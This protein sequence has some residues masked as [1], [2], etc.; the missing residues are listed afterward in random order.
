MRS[1]LGIFLALGLALT[2]AAP[3]Q[4]AEPVAVS[5]PWVRATAPG[6]DVGAAYMELKSA[7]DSALVGVTS[8]VTDSVEI[9]K[10][11]MNNGV[12][13]M[14]MLETLP[15]PAG[16]TVKLEPGGFHLMLFDLKKP[17]QAGAR[18]TFTLQIKDKQ[19]HTR[20]QIVRAPVR[21]GKD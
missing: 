9:H 3:V 12:M 2:V 13:E 21:A 16:K 4:A 15:L 6:Q 11:A 8:D 17:L 14:R 5:Q 19:G 7:T 1:E 20:R 10:M 18:V